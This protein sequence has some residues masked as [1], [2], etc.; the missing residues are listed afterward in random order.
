MDVIRSLVG[1]PGNGH[2][3]TGRADEAGDEDEEVRAVAARHV[4]PDLLYYGHEEHTCDR[5][6]DEGRDDLT[7]RTSDR[8]NRLEKEFR[9]TDQDDDGQKEDEWVE[10]HVRDEPADTVAEDFE[11]A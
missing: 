10:C 9:G 4:L 2:A 8:V 11:Q 1:E 6:A 5:M 7:C 3:H